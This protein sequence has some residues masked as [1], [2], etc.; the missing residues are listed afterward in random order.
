MVRNGLGDAVYQAMQETGLED[1]PILYV[2]DQRDFYRIH[3]CC[4]NKIVGKYIMRPLHESVVFSL[5]Y[6]QKQLIV[7]FLL[8]FD[9]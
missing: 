3:G 6:K 7:I 1:F 4:K 2:V 5:K 9:N 8:G